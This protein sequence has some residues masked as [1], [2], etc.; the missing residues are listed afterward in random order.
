MKLFYIDT[1]DDHC[2]LWLDLDDEGF[3]SVEDLALADSISES[4]E[5]FLDNPR[6]MEPDGKDPLF[7]VF[8]ISEQK[9][10]GSY[11]KITKERYQNWPHRN[12]I[13]TLMVTGGQK[14]DAEALIQKYHLPRSHFRAFSL[15]GFEQWDE[16]PE[17][18][19]AFQELL[20]QLRNTGEVVWSLI[21]EF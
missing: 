2:D 17:K 11:H 13:Y 4:F 5:I 15:A 10:A 19:Q 20:L 7:L 6:A 1:N 3:E 9:G 14:A 18:E 16:V 8:H 12:N 21:D